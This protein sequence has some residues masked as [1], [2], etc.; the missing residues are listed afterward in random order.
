MVNRQKTGRDQRGQAEWCHKANSVRTS[1]YCCR[2]LDTG[3]CIV[4]N[5]DPG[6]SHWLLITEFHHQHHGHGLPMIWELLLPCHHCQGRNSLY[7]QVPTLNL[8]QVLFNW[9]CSIARSGGMCVQKWDSFAL[10]TCLILFGIW[11]LQ[12]KSIFS[13]HYDT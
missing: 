5:S 8:S 11:L 7:S 13:V 9:P 12:W 10:F 2:N 3:D 4:P 6:P 1:W